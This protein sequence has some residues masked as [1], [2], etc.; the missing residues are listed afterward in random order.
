MFLIYGGLFFVLFVRM[1]LIQATGEAEGQALAA[2]ADKKYSRETTLGASRGVIYD[3]S[4]EII[5]KDTLSYRLTAILSP[6]ATS[7]VDN[8]RHVVD[9]E[10]T[11]QILAKYIPLSE[12]EIYKRL[13]KN[14]QYQ[15]EFGKAGRDISHEIMLKIQ[16]EELPGIVFQ[17]DLKRLYP[18]GKFASHLIGFALKEESEDGKVTTKG[19]MGLERTYNKVLTGQDG[20]LSYKSDLW[21]YLLPNK[22]QILTPAQNGHDIY[23]TLDK[24]IQSFLEDA[25]N[26]VEAEYEPAKMVA[27]VADPNT[28]AILAMS[29][30]P[31]FNPQT[32]EGLTS[33]WLND[34]VENTIEP[35]STMKIVTL[36]A[37]IEEGKW[38]P[39]ATYQSG[40]YRLLDRTIRDHNAGNGWGRITYLEGFQRSSNVAMGYLLE[41]IGDR[42]FIEYV[43][44][45]GFGEKT[46]IDL[47]NEATGTIMDTYPSERLTTSFGQGTTV[48]PIQMIQA[49]TAI[50]NDGKMMEPYVIDKIVNPNTDE[51][52]KNNGPSEKS[53]PISKETA[54]EVRKIMASTITAEKGTAKRFALDGYTVAGKTGTAE[55]PDPDGRGYL[56]GKNNFLYSFIG[57]APAEDPELLLYIAVQQPKLKETEVGSQ[58]VAEIFTSV[59]ENSL[60]YLSIEPASEIKVEKTTLGAYEGREIQGA[61]QELKNSGLVPVVIGESGKITAQYPA[62]NTEILKGQ[63]VFLK[64]EGQV[65]IPDFTGWSKRN[66]LI[67]KEMSGLRI[68]TSGE[69]FVHS[70]SVS[71]GNTVS[72]NSPVV[73]KLQT[74]AEVYNNMNSV[75][76]ESSLPQD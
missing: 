33:N 10:K 75:N 25:M 15:V 6:K 70:Q 11:A 2:L 50:A 46:G 5:A 55:I 27:V 52:V 18:N 64:T 44:K 34:A 71:A 62:E 1:F 54:E 31:S 74:P 58:P 22:E 45:F 9:P 4:G 38:D 40:R 24:T 39:S 36:A 32:L 43:E 17:R 23:L 61:I 48:T 21:G 28:G 72:G 65:A 60:K 3:Q 53:K 57:M 51:I 69:G 14:E 26:R 73:L 20:K 29:Q 7:D 30:R 67:F 76:E 59:A 37:A 56:W 35:G 42:K 47:P 68:E 19:K 41:K 49:G 12:E 63:Q 66:V 16:Q 13:S 8:P